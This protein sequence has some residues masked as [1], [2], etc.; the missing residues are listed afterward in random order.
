MFPTMDVVVRLYMRDTY[1]LMQANGAF[2]SAP[3]SAPMS[4]GYAKAKKR[5]FDDAHEDS[6]A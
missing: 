2:K 1:N 5:A 4:A 6:E 3:A